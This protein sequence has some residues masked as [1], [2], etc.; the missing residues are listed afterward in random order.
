[1]AGG[2]KATRRTLAL[3]KVKNAL[4]EMLSGFDGGAPSTIDLVVVTRE[5]KRT[6]AEV[7]MV[8][9]QR[10]RPTGLDL[11]KTIHHTVEREKMSMCPPS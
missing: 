7:Q 8:C 6:R 3:P 10:G 11:D 9:G 5:R 4:P 2:S 1:V